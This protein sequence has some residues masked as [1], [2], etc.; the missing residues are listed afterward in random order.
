MTEIDQ[1]HESHRLQLLASR[2]VLYD[3]ELS[4]SGYKIVKDDHGKPHV[5]NIQGDISFTHSHDHAAAMYS[6]TKLVGIDIQI[7]TDKISRI[8]PKFISTGEYDYIEL[9]DNAID[10]YHVLWGA[11]ESMYKAYGRRK[12]DFRVHLKVDPF[13]YNP[14]GGK[15]SGSVMMPDYNGDFDIY[16]QKINAYYLVYCVEKSNH[17]SPPD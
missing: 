7:A 14:I 5:V 11:K 8:A 10:Y 9:H 17:E 12:V 16:Y 15:I 1:K 3:M 13:V 6:K 4:D 2:A